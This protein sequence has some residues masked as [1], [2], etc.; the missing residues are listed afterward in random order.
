[1]LH[2]RVPATSANMGSGFDSVGVAFKMYNHIWVEEIDEGLEIIVK[3]KQELPVP[4]DKTNLIYK[5]ISD[6]YKKRNLNLP[7][8]RIIQ[9][10]NIPLTRGLGSSA[11]CIVGGLMAG[12]ALAKTNYTK[13]DIAQIAAKMEGHPDNSNPAIFGGMVV[14]ALSSEEMRYVSLDMPRFLTFAVMIPDFPVSTEK[15][16][17]VLPY[18]VY[19]KDAVYNSS[20]A[21]LLVASMI[22]GR[23][24]N[25][26]MAMSDKLHQPYRQ[27][28]VPGMEY[29]LAAAECFGGKGG[30]LSGAGPTLVSVLDEK[31]VDD[32]SEKMTSY[33]QS[34]PNNWQLQILKP[35]FEGAKIIED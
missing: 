20:R 33:L 7:G 26:K 24:D 10:D 14:G 32:F 19:R 30:Y 2:I 5:T 27:P 15:S 29:I 28:L 12:N 8:I 25:L 21:A 4:L 35:D 9:E 18:T 17:N 34:I 3:K 23:I 6:F 13:D 31:D 11:A 16:R 22:T 1:M